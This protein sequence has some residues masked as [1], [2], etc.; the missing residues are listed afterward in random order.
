MHI[1]VLI[2]VF[3]HICNGSFCSFSGNNRVF[4]NLPYILLL[5]LIAHSSSS[6]IFG[7]YL[8]TH[9]DSVHARNILV[10]CVK[11]PLDLQTSSHR[12]ELGNLRH[13]LHESDDSLELEL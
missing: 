9:Q 7:G 12:I 13:G 5:Y 4:T 3:G 11:S 10:E 8:A 1:R 2:Q 6:W